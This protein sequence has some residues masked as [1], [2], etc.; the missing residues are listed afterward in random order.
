[1]KDPNFK[2][3]TKFYLVLV[4]LRVALSAKPN[5]QYCSM[6][7]G[8][9]MCLYTKFDSMGLGCY[10]YNEIPS[11]TLQYSILDK[12]NSLRN[13]YSEF[14]WGKAQFQVPNMLAFVWDTELA[15]IAAR[16]AWQCPFGEDDYRNV[17]RFE[18]A[19]LVGILSEIDHFPSVDDV[20]RSLT[21]G[22]HTFHELRSDQRQNGSLKSSFNS[23][24]PLSILT[25]PYFKYVGCAAARYQQ[26]VQD[27]REHRR[28][29]V[30]NYGPLSLSY[31]SNQPSDAPCSSCP[32]GTSCYSGSPYPNLCY[33]E[34][35][36]EGDKLDVHYES[37][38][39]YEEFSLYKNSTNKYCSEL[40]KNGEVHTK[41]KYQFPTDKYEEVTQILGEQM[42]TVLLRQHNVVRNNFANGYWTNIPQSSPFQTKY[43]N[44]Q[45]TNLPL[46]ANMREMQWNDDLALSASIWTMQCIAEKD[47][48][49][50]EY[51]PAGS[52]V[53]EYVTQLVDAVNWT[54]KDGFPNADLS[55]YKWYSEHL[56]FTE[57]KIIPFSN[58]K[59]PTKEYREFAQ[60][61]W[62]ESYFLG[63]ATTVCRNNNSTSS[64]IVTACNYGPGGVVEGRNVYVRGGPCTHCMILNRT[65]HGGA[66]CSSTYPYLCS[67]SVFASQRFAIQALLTIAGIL[68]IL[69]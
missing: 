11:S 19:N 22:N 43:S 9:T 36:I 38:D 27:V 66:Y 28:I 42:K 45:S 63:C 52:L 50:D 16:W 51:L 10:D 67:G 59:D 2:S 15:D 46:A 6:N 60:I 68:L 12:H 34:K 48:C 69:Q 18:V 57:D 13:H 8:H 29:L 47:K 23:D 55:F 7:V 61:I 26:I 49:R 1:M 30:C 17:D 3:L 24:E 4:T 25:N 39:F 54:G 14:G 40:C 37:R 41:C 32:E 20:W 58:T 31:D 35:E 21:E 62:A 64:L 53:R 5:E 65:T 56:L 44:L 33:D